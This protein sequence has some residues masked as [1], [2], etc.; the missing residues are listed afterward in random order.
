MSPHPSRILL[1]EREILVFNDIEEISEFFLDEWQRISGYAIRHHGEFTVAL[2]GG[3]TPVRVYERLSELSDHPHWQNTHIFL[4]DERY[5]P[6]DH[7]DSNYHMIR[8]TLLDH[9]E[10]PEENI[11]PIPVDDSSP[12]ESAVRYETE[13]RLYFKGEDIPVFNLILLGIGVDGHTASLF[14]ESSSVRESRLVIDITPQGRFGHE[15][16]TITLPVINNAENIFFIVT[17]RDKADVLKRVVVDNDRGLPASLV[18]PVSGQI[19]FLIDRP[20]ARL[21]S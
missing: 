8:Q 9:I 19:I 3:K 20:A 1:N 13:L 6:F 11:H 12:D 5:V 2:S 17:G 15:R 7:P 16:V 4:V 10:I 21:I 14:P 18:Q